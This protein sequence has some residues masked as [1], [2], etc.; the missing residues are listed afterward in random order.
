MLSITK[1]GLLKITL[2]ESASALP[3]RDELSQMLDL[4]LIVRTSLPDDKQEFS[5][6][7][8]SLDGNVLTV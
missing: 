7:V 2:A 3:S 1:T 8:I 5:W 6:A 4:S